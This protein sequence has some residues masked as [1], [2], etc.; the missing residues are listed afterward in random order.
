MEYSISLVVIFWIIRIFESVS[1]FDLYF[2]GIYP[3]TT[4]GL[5]GIITAP[6]IHANFDHLI[7]N[8]LPFLSLSFLLFLFYK[9]KAGSVFVLLWITAGF[10]TW[11]IGR[12]A[13]H[14]GASIM[15]YALAF[16]LFFGGIMSKK[17][18]LILLSIGIIILY[19][20]LI[21][22]ILPV[23][24]QISWEG[25]LSGAASGLVWAYKFRKEI[26]RVRN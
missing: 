25:H 9:K 5:P 3:R 17:F 18:L 11:L 22:G 13:W 12:P 19:G 16:F 1:G 24:G 10:F 6:F 20:G 15:I 7:A 8:T 14:I 26:R 23:A 2:L 21:W 4:T